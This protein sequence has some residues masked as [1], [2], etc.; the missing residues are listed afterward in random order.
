MGCN[1]DLGGFG[2]LFDMREANFVGDDV[3][4][5]ACNDGVGTKLK[6]KIK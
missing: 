3:V 4:L 6:V 1:V 2:G 5:V